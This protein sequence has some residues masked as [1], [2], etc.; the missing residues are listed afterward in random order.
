VEDIRLSTDYEH[1]VLAKTVNNIKKLGKSLLE[2]NK[3]VRWNGETKRYACSLKL[4]TGIAGIGLVVAMTI[5]SELGD[6]L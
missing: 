2:I 4:L 1:S 3:E 5:K 6:I